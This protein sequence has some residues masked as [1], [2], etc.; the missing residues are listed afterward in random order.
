MSR[1]G[2]GC[3]AQIWSIFFAVFQCLFLSFIYPF[4][5][6]DCKQLICEP[7]SGFLICLFFA[8]LIICRGSME[9]PWCKCEYFFLSFYH[10]GI[11]LFCMFFFAPRLDGGAVVQALQLTSSAVDLP[12]SAHVDTGKKQF[13]WEH[14]MNFHNITSYIIIESQSGMTCQNNVPNTFQWMVLNSQHFVTF[15]NM[16]ALTNI[17]NIT[18]LEKV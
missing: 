1:L 2:G 7:I 18:L 16:I 9:V 17:F 8:P 11:C 15:T 4:N 14:Q 5:S 3:C 13:N 10:I 12:P 6:F